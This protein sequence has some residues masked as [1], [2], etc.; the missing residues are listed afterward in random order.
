[1]SLSKAE[2]RKLHSAAI[3]QSSGSVDISQDRAVDA[4]LPVAEGSANNRHD[5]R[6]ERHG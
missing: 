3:R 5:R 6:R 4:R 1:M 2:D